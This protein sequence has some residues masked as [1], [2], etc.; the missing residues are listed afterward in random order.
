M[1]L[2]ETKDSPQFNPEEIHE[3]D[4]MRAKYHTW[5]EPRN[6]LVATVRKDALTVI[7]MPGVHRAT[8]YFSVKAQ[9]VADGKWEISYTSDMETI[10]REG[11]ESGDTGSADPPEIDDESTD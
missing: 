2:I 8:C 10:G 9:E 4:L 3:R 1:A 7:F 5:P 6:G 11:R